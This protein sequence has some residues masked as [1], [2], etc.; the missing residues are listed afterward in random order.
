MN[1]AE[2]DSE[3]EDDSLV[4]DSEFEEGEASSEGDEAMEQQ[5]AALASDEDDDFEDDAPRRCRHA[6]VLPNMPSLFTNSE[7]GLHWES[8]HEWHPDC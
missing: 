1:L 6:P 4:D 2:P 3:G 8:L 5:V 7:G